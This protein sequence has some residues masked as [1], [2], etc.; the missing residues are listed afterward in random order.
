MAIRKSPKKRKPVGRKTVRKRGYTGKPA[1]NNG[2]VQGAA[3]SAWP[4]WAP[5]NSSR[6]TQ[7]KSPFTGS[8]GTNYM[9]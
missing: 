9:R 8:T 1:T 3:N 6:M 7:N 5:N 2:L 4:M